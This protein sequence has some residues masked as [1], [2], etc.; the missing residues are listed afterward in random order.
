MKEGTM[1]KFCKELKKINDVLENLIPITPEGCPINS[2]S[3]ME[4]GFGEI[5]NWIA[6]KKGI[7]LPSKVLLNDEIEHILDAGYKWK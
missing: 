3:K 5:V 4:D 7:S 2:I 1:E 6:N